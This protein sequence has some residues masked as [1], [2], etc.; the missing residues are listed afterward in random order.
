VAIYSNNILNSDK[1]LYDFIEKYIEKGIY[2]IF[3]YVGPDN[4]IVVSYEKSELVLL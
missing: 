1:K 4:R 2:P 3:E